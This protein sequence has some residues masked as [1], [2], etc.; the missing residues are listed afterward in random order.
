MYSVCDDR[1]LTIHIHATYMYEPW[2]DMYEPWQDMCE[3]WQDMYEPWHDMY[4]PW[5]EI[6]NNVVKNDIFTFLQFQNI[7]PFAIRML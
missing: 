5:H 1:G 2:Q 4:E 7:W 3:P 6:S